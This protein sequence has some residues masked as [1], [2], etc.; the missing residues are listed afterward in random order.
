V[1]NIEQKL[2]VKQNYEKPMLRVIE[3]A[4][5]EVLAVGCKTINGGGG[6]PTAIPCD[7]GGCQQLGS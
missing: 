7:A 6:N 5:E 1:E 4:A 2:N 3:L